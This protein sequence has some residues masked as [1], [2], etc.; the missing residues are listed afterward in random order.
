MAKHLNPELR[1]DAVYLVDVIDG[2]L[3]G[4]PDAANQPRQDFESQQGI[5]TDACLKRKVRD[6]VAQCGHEIFVQQGACLNNLIEAAYEKSGILTKEL[7]Q[8]DDKGKYKNKSTEEQQL[9]AQECLIRQ[10]YDIRMFGGVV[11]TGLKAGQVTGPMQFTFARSVDPITP[12]T[13]TVSRCAAT[14]GKEGKDNKTLGKKELIPYGLYRSSI[15]YNPNIARFVTSEDLEI[16]W[17]SLLNCWEVNRSASR[18]LIACRGL[19]V[20]THE[21]KM[22]SAPTHTLL[23]SVQIKKKSEGAPRHFSDY[24]VNQLDLDF[25]GITVTQLR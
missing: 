13:V 3:N 12:M 1:H 4:D 8:K 24:D 23:D 16:F 7:K 9:I 14:E 21:A 10:Y 20:F 22:G 5:A 15:F 2:S 11:G 19:W 17:E 25:P 18:G 6:Y